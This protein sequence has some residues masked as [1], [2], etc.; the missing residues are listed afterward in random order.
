[1][2]M[3]N[4]AHDLVPRAQLGRGQNAR[5]LV[6]RRVAVR[7]CCVVRNMLPLACDP[8]NPAEGAEEVL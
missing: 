8:I 6:S 4:I 1:M 5:A 3:R 7:P 2:P